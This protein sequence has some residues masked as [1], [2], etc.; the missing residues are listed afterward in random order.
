[1]FH[2]LFCGHSFVA[3]N[4]LDECVAFVNVDNTCL[5]S[6]EGREDGTQFFLRRSTNRSDR[7]HKVP[8]HE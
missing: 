2:A 4:H 6:A 1:M 3:G 5:H 7:D 8:C